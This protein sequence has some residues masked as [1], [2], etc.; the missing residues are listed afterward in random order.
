MD[1]KDDYYY[2]LEDEKSTKPYDDV[3]AISVLLLETHRALL[4]ATAS[5]H[6]VNRLI[7]FVLLLF[8]FVYGTPSVFHLVIQLA[9]GALVSVSWLLHESSVRRR[10]DR[11]EESIVQADRSKAAQVWV[12]AY[13]NW[14]HARWEQERIETLQRWEP[15]LWFVLLLG[16]SLSNALISISG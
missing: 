9:V 5:V 6:L 8:Q 13:I 12:E 10:I 7:L 15:A 1:N 11:I 14:Q 4:R 16:L 2:K 3:E